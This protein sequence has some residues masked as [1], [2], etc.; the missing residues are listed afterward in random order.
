MVS[1]ID[2]VYTN[3]TLLPQ[4]KDFTVLYDVMSSD[5]RP[6]SFAIDAGITVVIDVPD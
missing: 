4:L 1:W 5:H 2:H 3:E 6:L